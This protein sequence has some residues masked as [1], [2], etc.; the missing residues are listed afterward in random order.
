M[1]LKISKKPATATIVETQKDKGKVVS[2]NH[3]QEKVEVSEETTSGTAA[4]PLCEI[5]FESSYTHNLGDFKSARVGVSIS[6]PCEFGEVDQV[7]DYA[8]EWVNTRMEKL[9]ADLVNQ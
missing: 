4:G 5:G 6:I 3:V 9:V 8:E 7:A 2:E 1:A